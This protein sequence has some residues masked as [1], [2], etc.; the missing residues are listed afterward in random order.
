MKK[1]LFF[2]LKIN[3]VFVQYGEEKMAFDLA[4]KGP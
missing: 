4:V 1:T 2:N 3:E